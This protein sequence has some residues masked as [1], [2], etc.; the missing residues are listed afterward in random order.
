VIP[1]AN[2]KCCN[3]LPEITSNKKVCRLQSTGRTTIIT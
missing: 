3:K 2:E 1:Q